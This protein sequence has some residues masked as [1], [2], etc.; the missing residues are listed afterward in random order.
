MVEI[1]EIIEDLI[2]PIKDLF[3]HYRYL[4]LFD[5]F[6]KLKNTLKIPDAKNLPISNYDPIDTWEKITRLTY[7]AI[8]RV[9]LREK[10]LELLTLAYKKSFNELHKHQK[11]QFLAQKLSPSEKIVNEESYLLKQLQNY[12]DVYEGEYK[13]LISFYNITFDILEGEN[14]QPLEY[15]YSSYPSTVI[16]NVEKL[17]KK[18]KLVH[19]ADWIL[20]GADNNIRNAVAHKNWKF[21][22]GKV[23][24]FNLN[25]KTKEIT[26]NKTFIKIELEDKMKSLRLAVLGMQVGFLLGFVKYETKIQKIQPRFKNDL[27]S[28]SIIMYGTAIQFEFIMDGIDIKKMVKSK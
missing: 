5:N 4:L 7:E 14:L 28:L 6:E 15:Y 27:E 23:E 20:I 24:L 9:F 13:A 16:K 11:V 12:H 2:F 1:Y 19:N 3:G 8:E 26:W 18:V 21:F 22:N 17:S 10:E 25:P